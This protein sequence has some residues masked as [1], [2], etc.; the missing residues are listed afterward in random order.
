MKV[1]AAAGQGVD[2]ARFAQP[3]ARWARLGPYYAM[4]PLPF[5]WDVLQRF[6]APEQTV[7]D[8]FCGRGTAPYLAQIAGRRAWGCEINPVAWVY[9][10][11]KMAPY[12]DPDA[13]LQ[14]LAEINAAVRPRNRRP[15]NEFQR[16]AFHSDVL[17]FVNAARRELQWKDNPRDR[18]VAA[19]LL[20]S[21]HSKLKDGLSNQMRHS[22]ALAPQYCID[23]WQRHDLTVPPAVNPLV[24]L[25]QRVQWRYAKGLPLHAGTPH[26]RVALGEASR[27]LR[28]HGP[29]QEPVRLILTSPPYR[30]VTN[31][32]LDN[33]LRLWALRAGPCWPQ[34]S[35]REKYA[36]ADRYTRLLRSVFDAVRQHA[37]R[38]A[39]WY[40]R[41][42]ARARTRTVTARVLAS[43]LPQH[44]L[45]HKP[46]PYRQFTQ[47]ALYG[48][49]TEKPGEI[50]LLFLP[51][52]PARTAPAGFAPYVA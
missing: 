49:K 16:L 27:C 45:W 24:F 36:S 12:P 21:L 17:G 48:D 32:R 6:S 4:F 5:A 33:W 29:E 18:T 37:S 35:A 43:L 28:A 15:V 2:F 40:V 9:A 50:D 47:T 39:V 23:W 3:E 7:L 26:S 13:V 14:R 20:H 51:V 46:A 25:Q 1:D 38:H 44:V 42:D 10:Q 52:A 41:T 11:V 22:R 31:Y 19:F 30:G 34:W 8:P